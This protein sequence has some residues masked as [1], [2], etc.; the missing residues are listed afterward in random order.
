MNVT[1]VTSNQTA[2][3]LS[4]AAGSAKSGADTSNAA[5]KEEPAVFYEA[6]K[7][8]ASSEKKTYAQDTVLI[9]RLKADAEA[10]TA[11]FR[12]LVEKM[13]SQQG[14]TYRKANGLSGG[15]LFDVSGDQS[16]SENEIWKFLAS[17]DYTVDAATKLQAQK[18]IADDGYWG[19]EQTSSRILDFANALTGGDPDKIEDMRA[20]FE[21]GFR[22][23]TAAWGKDLPDLSRKTYEA[24][25]GKFDQLAEEADGK[26][27][28]S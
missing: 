15:N 22:L 25:M 13:M 4:M 1:G 7:Q 28:E 3:Y 14:N 18:D 9:S 12:S 16:Q 20:A 21:K 17:G 26:K 10:R 6:S 11:Q 27:K 23:A 24:V 19:A 2:A 5:A 8:T